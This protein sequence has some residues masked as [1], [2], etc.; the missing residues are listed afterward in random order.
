MKASSFCKE[1]LQLHNEDFLLLIRAFRKIAKF[2]EDKDFKL[3]ILPGTTAYYL[4][5]FIN[6]YFKEK[7]KKAPEIIAMGRF[8]RENSD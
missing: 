2:I 8:I 6:G 5:W 3:I 4:K 1:G 7:G